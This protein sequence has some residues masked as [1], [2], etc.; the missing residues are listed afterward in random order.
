MEQRRT[1]RRDF[2]GF[3]VTAIAVSACSSCSLIGSRKSDA[4][5]PEEAGILRL[6]EV[7][8]STLLGTETSLLVASKGGKHKILVIHRA[9]GNLFAVSAACT[10]IGCD[11][12]YDKKLGH[13]LCPCHGAQ[14]GLG[15]DNIKG[16]AKRPLKSYNVGT[17]NGRVVIT[18]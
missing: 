6:S 12:E 14:Y 18:L 4:V 2:L 16:P 13:L 3:G 11:V 17:E 9:D 7:D 8:S 10:H 15:G 1:S 5:V